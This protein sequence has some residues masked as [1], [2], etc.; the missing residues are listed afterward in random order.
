MAEMEWELERL[1]GGNQRGNISRVHIH[2]AH[3]KLGMLV[4]KLNSE[5]EE[6]EQ[7]GWIQNI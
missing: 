2:L 1:E 5:P 6:T 3:D 4:L 7:E